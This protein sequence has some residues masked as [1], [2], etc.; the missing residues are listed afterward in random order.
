MK[1]LKRKQSEKKWNNT[2]LNEDLNWEKIYITLIIATNEITLREFQYKC[3][4]RMIPSNSF[5]HKCILVSSSL[6][7]FCIMEIKTLSH[8][9]WECRYVQA[10]W[11]HLK[12]FLFEIK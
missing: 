1:T 3:L 7:D 10:L 6:F 9:F 5:F 4:K 2:F 12:N 8:L 11:M